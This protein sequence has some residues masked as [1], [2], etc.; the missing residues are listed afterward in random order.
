MSKDYGTSTEQPKSTYASTKDHTQPAEI[1]KVR[2]PPARRTPP[3]NKKVC[4]MHKCDP[5][6]EALEKKGYKFQEQ[7]VE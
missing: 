3:D 7:E 6:P 4:I 5:I 2:T 1:I